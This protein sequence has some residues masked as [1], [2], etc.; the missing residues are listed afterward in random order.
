MKYSVTAIA[1]DVQTMKTTKPRTEV[2]DTKTNLLFESCTSEKDVA[3]MYQAFWDMDTYTEQV[4]VTGVK[5]IKTIKGKG[6]K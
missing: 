3:E 2:I 5:A 6:K 1:R 4:F